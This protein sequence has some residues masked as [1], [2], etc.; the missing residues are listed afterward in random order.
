M[1]KLL[2]GIELKEGWQ[3][4]AL[5]AVTGF[6]L[7]IIAYLNFQD[8]KGL[9]VPL[10]MLSGIVLIGVYFFLYS[11]NEEKQVNLY[12][13]KERVSGGQLLRS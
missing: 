4:R 12:E 5:F 9:F 11:R 2:Q 13:F 6:I 7:L 1:K 10:M 8:F 3:T